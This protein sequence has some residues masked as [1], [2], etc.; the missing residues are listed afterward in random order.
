MIKKIGC[1][2]SIVVVLLLSVSNN[3]VV[4]AEAVH[5]NVTI[6]L[7]EPD[8]KEKDH[9][10]SGEKKEP[11]RNKKIHEFP[12]TGE[13]KKGWFVLIGICVVS[14]SLAIMKRNRRNSDE[15]V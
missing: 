7:I 11:P 10:K 4:H 13:Q 6:K 14:I 3:S 5:S 12:Q 1:F 8:S 15:K 9:S 2:I